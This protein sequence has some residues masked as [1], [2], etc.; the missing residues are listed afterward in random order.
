MLKAAPQFSTQMRYEF[1][2]SVTEAV[3]MYVPHTV[4]AFPMPL[5]GDGSL[6]AI[7]GTTKSGGRAE[8]HKAILCSMSKWL[9]MDRATEAT[10]SNRDESLADE[11]LE[12]GCVAICIIQYMMKHDVH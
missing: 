6:K 4:K 5:T 2:N 9:V 3:V 1:Q 7:E 8:A 11:P 10:G 12:G